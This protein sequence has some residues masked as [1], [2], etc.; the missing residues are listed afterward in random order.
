M[1]DSMLRRRHGPNACELCE[2]KQATQRASFTAHFL[3]SEPTPLVVEEHVAK[4]QLEKRV[5][6]QCAEQLRNM[7]NVTD[8]TLESL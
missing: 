4:T 8:L 1:I 2:T 5:C 6:D 3:H 7:K